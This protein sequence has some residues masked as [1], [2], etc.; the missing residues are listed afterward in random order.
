[1]GAQTAPRQVF[2][3]FQKALLPRW[4]PPTNSSRA[5]A[6]RVV[7]MC[8]KDQLDLVALTSVFTT[9]VTSSSQHKEKNN[10]LPWQQQTA[11]VSG[12]TPQI[13]YHLIT[14]L[15]TEHSLNQLEAT[16]IFLPGHHPVLLSWCLWGNT[17]T[18][19]LPAHYKG[20]KLAMHFSDLSVSCY[21]LE[22]FFSHMSATFSRH[23]I[24]F[25]CRGEL[26]FDSQLRNTL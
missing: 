25:L 22:T 1:M 18:E 7:I 14:H 26:K 10:Q 9:L 15:V 24:Q 13:G 19:C 16:E 2:N 4:F 8:E 6:W 11:S 21:N 5:S 20:Q 23:P 3:V 12:N 17:H